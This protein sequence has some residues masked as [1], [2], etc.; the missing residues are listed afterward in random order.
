MKLPFLIWTFFFI[1]VAQAQM[2]TPFE[3]GDGNQS[4]AYDEAIEFY[5]ALSKES[6]QIKV[7]EIG[8]T[9]VG[10]PL[11]LV[12]ISQN[13]KFD[14][15]QLKQEGKL[16]LLINNGIHPGESAGIDASLI[17]ARDLVQKKEFSKAFENVVVGIIP[18]Y[19]VG[20]SINRSCCTRANQIG[21]AEQGFR[22]NAKNLDLNR[23]FIKMDSKNAKSF[24]QIFQLFDPDIFVDT[25]TSNGADYQYVMTLIT[26]Q[27]DK[28]HPLLSQYVTKNLEP[29]L[30]KKMAKENYPMIP[31]VNLM[32]WRGTPDSGITGFLETP[33]Y[34][35]GYSNLFNTIGFTTETHMLKPYDQRVK[36]TYKFLLNLL[37]SANKDCRQIKTIRETANNAVKHQ[38]E[39]PLNWKIDTS[40]FTI[41]DFKGY[42]ASYIPSKVSGLP[43]LNYNQSKPVTLKVKFFN[44]YLKQSHIKK[45]TAYI[46]PQAWE[47]VIE[48]LKLNKVEVRQLSRDTILP[49]ESYYINDYSTIDFPYE[50]HYLH[51]NTSVEE[52]QHQVQFR[53]GD[54]IVF[55]DQKRNRFIIETLEPEAI[56]SY[57]NWNFFDPILMQKEY[58][59]DY[60]FDTTA[61]ALLQKDQILKKDFEDKM[62]N[63]EAFAKNLYA[64]LNFI[65]KR[66][67]YAEKSF[68]RYPIVR[69]MQQID[70]PLQ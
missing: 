62:K 20:G 19:N 11:H 2:L 39:F 10:N 16:F 6:N 37:E 59:S 70:L 1:V 25:H 46:I 22:G 56:D 69:L 36:A 57:F 60:S 13:S 48:R 65:Y 24:A 18:V 40:K 12:L 41:L 68:K 35:T 34:A 45:P 5:L 43:V 50:G 7:I 63:D 38:K 58:F 14:L 67:P 23:D 31:Y 42:E 27:K 28:M 61:A 8:S 29:E 49:V 66:S 30:Y 15:E 9:D 52:K 53:K 3:K 17:L 55:M 64:Q 44:D 47:D 32:N 21:P 54:Y 33:R 4:A 51:Y 26:S